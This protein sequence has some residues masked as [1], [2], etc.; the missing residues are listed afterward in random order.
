MS[1]KD[2]DSKSLEIESKLSE[3]SE[4]KMELIS[5]PKRR[6]LQAKLQDLAIDTDVSCKNSYA[7]LISSLMHDFSQTKVAECQQITKEV[8]QSVVESAMKSVIGSMTR[9]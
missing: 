7:K 5:S 1:T 3:T 9:K 6:L 4:D 8:S 2:A